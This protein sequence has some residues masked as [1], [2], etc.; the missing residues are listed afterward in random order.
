[1]WYGKG[2]KWLQK[3]RVLVGILLLVVALN[4]LYV[5]YS[6]QE[7]VAYIG[8]ENAYLVAFLLAA[9]GGTSSFVSAAYFAALLTFGAGGANILLLGVIAGTGI[10]IGDSI[11]YLIAHYAHARLPNRWRQYTDRLTEWVRSFSKRKV[12]L[13]SY[14]YTGF[15][16]FPTDILI[17]VLAFAGYSYRAIAPVLFVGAITFA[18]FSATIGYVFL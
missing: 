6:P 16:P 11:F 7:I 8:V 14:L 17:I 12:F 18:T 4:V 5:L 3:H 2:V 15:S 10:F 13:V 1:M 9:I